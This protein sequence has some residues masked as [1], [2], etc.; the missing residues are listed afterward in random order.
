MGREDGIWN[1]VRKSKIHY[2]GPCSE[3]DQ[4]VESGDWVEVRNPFTLRKVIQIAGSSE[5]VDRFA[6]LFALCDDGTIWRMVVHH[7]DYNTED[8][9][10]QMKEIPQDEM[11]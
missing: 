10:A 8:Y 4:H 6:S 9:W 3:F 5:T 11:V 7:A 2:A 1:I